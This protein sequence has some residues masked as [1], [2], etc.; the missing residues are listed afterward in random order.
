MLCLLYKA[1]IAISPPLSIFAEVNS[2]ISLYVQCYILIEIKVT[3]YNTNHHE[4]KCGIVGQNPKLKG[5][6]DWE[7]SL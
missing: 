5:V 3:N 4:C 1:S 6:R 2:C 7:T